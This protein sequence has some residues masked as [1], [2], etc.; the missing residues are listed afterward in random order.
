MDRYRVWRQNGL[1]REYEWQDRPL[2]SPFRWPR[3]ARIAFFVT[4]PVSG[5]L[6]AAAALVCG[7]VMMAVMIVCLPV[8][9]LWEFG[10]EMLGRDG[11]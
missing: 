11:E 8:L 4:L 5:P 7:G 9:A 2:W 3:W 1:T 6:W 10:E